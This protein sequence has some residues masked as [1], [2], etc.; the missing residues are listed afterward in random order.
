M[1]DRRAFA[2]TSPAEALFFQGKEHLQ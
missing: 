1:M 2:G